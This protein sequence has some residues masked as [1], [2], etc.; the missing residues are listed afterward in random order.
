VKS[1]DP[2]QEEVANKDEESEEGD[3]GEI[4][5]L[6]SICYL[7]SFKVPCFGVFRNLLLS[8]VPEQS[9]TLFL[10]CASNS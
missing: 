6:Y 1:D 7:K 10:E 3:E 9:L 5:L 2:E 4:C 8:I